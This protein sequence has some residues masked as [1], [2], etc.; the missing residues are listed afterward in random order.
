MTLKQLLAS[1]RKSES[2]RHVRTQNP[3]VSRGTAFL[4]QQRFL[5]RALEK[6]YIGSMLY[7]FNFAEET[8]RA[9]GGQPLKVVRVLAND[10][11]QGSYV[12]KPTDEPSPH[13]S[14][15]EMWV[16]LA[17]IK[18]KFTAVYDHEPGIINASTSVSSDSS[19]SLYDDMSESEVAFDAVVE[20]RA[21]STIEELSECSISVQA[22]AEDV[23]LLHAL[24]TGN[25]HDFTSLARSSTRLIPFISKEDIAILDVMAATND[26]EAFLQSSDLDT[27]WLDYS[28]S[29]D[30]EENYDGTSSI[31]VSV[32]II[33]EITLSGR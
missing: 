25:Q 1:L 24:L 18:A 22:P 3:S 21:L 23:N 13:E 8:Q 26:L 15:H 6:H 32:D 28:V 14:V 9:E 29:S 16:K 4:D 11:G 2:K 27:I 5:P 30:T 33:E 20:K 17:H 10:L 31:D 19:F 7:A 12:H